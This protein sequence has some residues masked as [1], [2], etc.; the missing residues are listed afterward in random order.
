MLLVVK[1]A[2]R[3]ACSNAKLSVSNNLP[4]MSKNDAGKVLAANLRRLMASKPD[5]DSGPKLEKKAKVAQKT[6]S[7]V[8]AGRHDTQLST[9][10]KLAHPFGLEAYQLLIPA[11]DEPLLKIVYAYNTSADG[12]RLLRLAAA[13]A[14]S[15]ES[16]EPSRADTRKT[17]D[18]REGAVTSVPPLHT[19]IQ[20]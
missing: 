13:T 3:R 6:I 11:E 2:G 17:D 9:I 16:D 18:R 4:A 1:G 19:R 12:R 7:N 14:M 15:E 8:L 20:K 5:L 10:E